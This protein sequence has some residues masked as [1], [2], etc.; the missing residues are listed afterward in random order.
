LISLRVTQQFKFRKAEF[1][2]FFL[3]HHIKKSF[4]LFRR[5]RERERERRARQRGP[6]GGQKPNF[7]LHLSTSF[8][9]T[10]GQTFGEG[11]LL[12]VLHKDKKDHSR[13]DFPSIHA[14]D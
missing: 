12:Q 13:G 3:N 7:F 6:R 1:N 14:S 10:F 4:F 11:V 5:E 9:R 8:G 2:I